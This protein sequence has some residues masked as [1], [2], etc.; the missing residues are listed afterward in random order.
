MAHPAHREPTTGLSWIE[1]G[2]KTTVV[3]VR[4]EVEGWGGS[5]CEAVHPAYFQ[6]GKSVGF[7]NAIR[8]AGQN[9]IE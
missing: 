7:L 3:A 6:L 4:K 9:V 5:G 1:I 8:F 2:D